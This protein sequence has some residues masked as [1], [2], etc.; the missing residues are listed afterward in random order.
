MRLFIKGANI[1]PKVPKESSM[2][3]EGAAKWY[4][5]MD[6]TFIYSEPEKAVQLFE[7]SLQIRERTFDNDNINVA[8]SYHNIGYTLGINNLDFDR[9]IDH[10]AKRK[11]IFENTKLIQPSANSHDH[12]GIRLYSIVFLGLPWSLLLSE[13]KL[14]TSI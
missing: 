14:S 8:L 5:V 9:S 1:N 7:K 2:N 11:Q 4:F 6:G 3:D 13:K 10:L 12:Y